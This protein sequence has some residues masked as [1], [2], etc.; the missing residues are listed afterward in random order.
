MHEPGGLEVAKPHKMPPH[1]VTA[2]LSMK[3]KTSRNELSNLK[4][5][6]YN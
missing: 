4:P 1:P 6:T 5:D 2:L 3:K